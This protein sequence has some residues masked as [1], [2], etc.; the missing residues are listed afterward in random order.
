MGTVPNP[1]TLESRLAAFRQ[2]L[3]DLASYGTERATEIKA[4]AVE[5]E[6]VVED[7]AKTLAAKASEMVKRNPRAALAIGLGIGYALLHLFRRPR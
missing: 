2:S 1:R 3:R 5:A 7:H 4:Q 6:H